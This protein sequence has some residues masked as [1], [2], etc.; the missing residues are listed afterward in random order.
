MFE[1]ELYICCHF[2]N[3]LSN[4]QRKYHS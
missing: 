4:S 3:I 2:D 1:K